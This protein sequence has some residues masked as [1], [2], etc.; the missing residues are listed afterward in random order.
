MSLF[1][2]WRER[3]RKI[4]AAKY[5]V[6]QALWSL[7]SRKRPCIRR[8]SE[9]DDTRLRELA[10]A[11]L[12][13]KTFLEAVPNIEGGYDFI[14]GEGIPERT[15]LAIAAYGCLPVLRLGLDAILSL[16]TIIVTPGG[17]QLK[18]LDDDGSGVVAEYYEDV[19][20]D[21]SDYGPITVSA[22]DVD[23]S[24]RGDGYNVVIHEIAHRLDSCGSESDGIPDLPR[25][26]SL[27]EWTGAFAP[28]YEDAQA[29]AGGDAKRGGRKRMRESSLIDPYAAESPDEF[30]AVSVEYF[31]DD[32]LALRRAYPGVY[33][34]LARWLGQDPAGKAAG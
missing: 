32:P 4:A 30:F 7:L 16:R 3:R 23:Q 2:P 14:D 19:A 25:S 27:L 29:R 26:I 18:R 13:E 9:G 12:R 15:R 31:F 5:P 11:F 33:G 34:M 8:L 6:D 20:G 24:G 21:A 22:R 10:A 1:T 28:A 17:Y